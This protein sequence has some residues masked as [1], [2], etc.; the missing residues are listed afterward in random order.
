M[1]DGVLRIVEHTAGRFALPGDG[2]SN[3]SKHVEKFAGFV[4]RELAERSL[5]INGDFRKSDPVDMFLCG[6]VFL[7]SVMTGVDPVFEQFNGKLYR[8][9][10][11]RPETLR[12]LRCRG[13]DHYFWP[14]DRLF[15]IYDESE[16]GE[17]YG[18]PNYKQS[19]DELGRSVEAIGY[20][21][22]PVSYENWVKYAGPRLHSDGPDL[23]RPSIL[24]RAVKLRRTSKKNHYD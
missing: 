12:L 16:K 19:I 18:F 14:D 11:E 24:C 20:F 5:E 4:S 13:A 8:V 21:G 22:H 9:D 3:I 10:N 2:C 7:L 6:R 23:R 15:E 1:N 17:R